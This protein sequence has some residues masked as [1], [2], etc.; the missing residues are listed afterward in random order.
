[1]D[2]NKR[3]IAGMRSPDGRPPAAV[4]RMAT[5]DA[6]TIMQTNKTAGRCTVVPRHVGIPLILQRRS[7]RSAVRVGSCRS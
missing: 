3:S 5:M 2:R 7:V 6:N 4:A 1:M